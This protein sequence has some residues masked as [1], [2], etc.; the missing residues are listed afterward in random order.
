MI[1]YFYPFTA[2]SSV[3]LMADLFSPGDVT[4]VLKNKRCVFLGASI[5]RGLY[6]DL[7][8]LI[9]SKSLIPFEV[10]KIYIKFNNCL[11]EKA[12]LSQIS[13]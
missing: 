1:T 12:P 13:S 8:W 4:K 11:Q 10:S 5:V 2:V 9:N 3:F 7:L 6:K